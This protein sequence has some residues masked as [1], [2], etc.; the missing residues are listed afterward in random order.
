MTKGRITRRKFSQTVLAASALAVGGLLLV[1]RTTSMRR[2]LGENDVAGLLFGA[3]GV[4]YGAL[5]AFVVFAAWEGY[6]PALGSWMTDV[7][8]H[9][10]DCDCTET[11]T[12]ALALAT[13]AAKPVRLNS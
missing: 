4:L 7:M 8:L 9:T 6:S 5:L 10:Y 1:R 12:M 11:E 2:H 13:L 3:V